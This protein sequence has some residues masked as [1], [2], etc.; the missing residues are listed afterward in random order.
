M[1]TPATTACD[2]LVI[3]TDDGDELEAALD[4]HAAHLRTTRPVWVVATKG[5]NAPLGEAAI[6]EALRSRACID[7]KVAAVSAR[8]TA[9]RFV[10]RASSGAID[11]SAPRSQQKPLDGDPASK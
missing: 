1:G 2:L 8:L 9:M 11:A 6:R 10:S 4:A 3:R 7:T 5:R